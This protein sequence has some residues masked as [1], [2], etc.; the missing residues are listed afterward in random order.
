M[1]KLKIVFVLFLVCMDPI[2][3]LGNNDSLNLLILYKSSE[4]FSKKS[5]PF[6]NAIYHQI[7]NLP[8]NI[9]YYDI[10]NGLPNNEELKKYG[11]IISYYTTPR[12]KGAEEYLEWLTQ[13]IFNQR[14]VII[15]GNMGA[16]TKDGKT[17]LT[18]DILNKFYLLLG[19]EF[20]TN[21]T[22]ESRLL[23]VSRLD[24]QYLINSKLKSEIT[25]NNYYQFNSIHPKNK[26]YIIINRKDITNGDSHILVE[27][28]FGG[29]A[30][31]DYVTNNV[32]GKKVSVVDMGQFLQSCLSAPFQSDDLPQKRILGLLKKSED[33]TEYISYVHRF[34]FK[35]L[36]MLGYWTDYHFVEN[37]L[38]NT[39][40][41]STYSSVVTWFR[42][43]NMINGE[44][45]PSWLLN[46]IISNRKVIIFG[47]FG[48][49]KGVIKK[50]GNFDVD[51]WINRNKYNN[52]FYPFGLEFLGD[53]IGDTSVLRIKYK[54]P[55]IVEKDIP[56]K[57][58]DLTH[59]FMWKSVNTENKVFLNIER[60]DRQN[61]ESAFV[62]R[63]PYGGFAFENYLLK[64][65]SIDNQ[66]KFHINIP[67][68]LKECLS[69]NP[70]SLPK[71]IPLLTHAEILKQTLDKLENSSDQTKKL[72]TYNIPPN[73]KELKRWVLVLYN[74]RENPDKSPERFINNPL[75][76]VLNHLGLLIEYRDVQEVLP[77][78]KH[79]E[80]FLG[81]ISTFQSNIMKDPGKYSLWV[82]EQLKKGKKMVIMGSF[83]AYIDEDTELE[84]KHYKPVFRALGLKHWD[85][86]TSVSKKQKIIY[87]SPEMMDFEETLDA[88]DIHLI[89]NKITSENQD[90]QVFLTIENSSIG[91]IDAVVVTPFGGII[92]DDLGFHSVTDKNRT[93]VIHDYINGH[94]NNAGSGKVNRGYWRINP[95]LFFAKAFDLENI[96][97][98]DVTTLNGNRIFY[99]HID[100]DGLTGISFI[101]RS[102]YSGEFVRD[103][104]LKKYPLPF[105]ASV[106]SNEIEKNGLPYYNK[107]YAV[108]RSIFALENV[109]AATHS[110]THP[111]NWLDGDLDI[112]LN[113]NIWEYQAKELDYD[114]EIYGSVRFIEKNLLPENKK[115][116]VYLW[117][118]Q[119]NPDRRAFKR[120][121]KMNL[122]NLNA[123]DPIFDSKFPSYS[124]LAS[125]A[126]KIDGY[127]QYHTSAS[128]D[129]IYTNGW[130]RNFGS[131]RKLVEHYEYTESPR[132]VLPINI[133]IHFYIGDRQEGLDGVKVAYDYCMNSKIT[134][135]FSSEYV[136]IIQD[137]ILL[138]QYQLS[139]GGYQISHDGKLRTIRF[140]NCEK[141]P[142][143]EKSN[144]VIGFNKYQNSLY[145]HLNDGKTQTVYLS[146]KVPEEV[147]L[148][149]GSQKISGW[150]A[151]KNKIEFNSS[152]I[153]KAEFEIKNLNKKCEYAI[154]ITETNEQHVIY[155]EKTETNEMGDLIFDSSFSKYHGKYL[156]EITKI[157]S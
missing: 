120:L 1:S 128:N 15:I 12:L 145:I 105:T 51:W 89:Y 152:G 125:F 143:L 78:D 85:I 79:M 122:L 114:L 71:P 126:T 113:N 30:L 140:D 63:T 92:I 69:Y 13:Q 103:Q 47:N 23:S 96:P 46:Q 54:N 6:K 154:V 112:N 27:T 48:A 68:F 150:K 33:S 56:I 16:Y 53:W 115:V 156:V 98:P 137:F 40:Q 116:N 86:E 109:E 14:K 34:L 146:N 41:M 20:K 66:L 130:T 2:L 80:K 74:S 24:S 75:A 55:Q 138:K 144:G 32:N 147:Y 93:S 133:Y 72:L 3:I 11:A 22:S 35:H 4:G 52:F 94:R 97:I 108:S 119:C 134:P 73:S 21:W 64:W 62:V 70:K 121:E 58:T 135:L 49:F 45:Y 44:D 132:R 81:I 8:Y 157:D 111:F 102:S 117:S 153:G 10:E 7:A 37:G 67:E 76:I 110:C 99:S 142:D 149:H 88:K 118:G 38:P 36:F 60:T 42:T 123:G 100:G 29:M 127:W 31:N 59:Y 18:E 39:D 25:V 129:F 5:N 141:Y 90:N 77:D 57:N 28:P 82:Q 148:N 136:S 65:D 124:N 131:M 151:S 155:N 83:G 101:D 9:E 19:L 26:S 17:W 61:S 91:K 84:I 95:F 87:K 43:P 139:D 107:A 106:I 50:P 104:I